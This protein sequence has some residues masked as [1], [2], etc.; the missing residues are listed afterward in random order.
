[1]KDSCQLRARRFTH[2]FSIREAGVFW[3]L[4]YW[5][6]TATFPGPQRFTA[7]GSGPAAVS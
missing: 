5:L 7:S 4:D 2:E 3:G 1:M 6:V